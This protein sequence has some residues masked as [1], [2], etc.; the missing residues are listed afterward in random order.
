[1][2]GLSG[3]YLLEL[4]AQGHFIFPPLLAHL[5]PCRYRHDPLVCKCHLPLFTSGQDESCYSA[6]SL[7]KKSWL[8]LGLG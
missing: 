3:E 4:N 5:S 7:P 1:M 6:Y 8:G 2:T